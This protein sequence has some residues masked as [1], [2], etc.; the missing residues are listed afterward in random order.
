MKNLFL[1]IIFLL[2]VSCGKTE[3]KQVYKDTKLNSVFHPMFAQE[4]LSNDIVR[5]KVEKK[6]EEKFLSLLKEPNFIK[7]Y[8]VL[9]ET[10][11]DAGGGMSWVKFRTA[12]L[13][14][15]EDKKNYINYDAYSFE[16][17]G[18][19]PT[20]KAEKLQTNVPYYVE[21]EMIE[22]G[23]KENPHIVYLNS[24]GKMNFGTVTY[25]IKDVLN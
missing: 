24:E 2:T 9:F 5:N 4:D 10:G 21:G 12:I 17:I 3:K 25:K 19:M 16:I 11:T 1:L 18:E 6:A 22:K 8:P 7:D 23:W 20:D 13:S 15:F 14:E